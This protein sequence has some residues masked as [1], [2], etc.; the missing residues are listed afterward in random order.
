MA[1]VEVVVLIANF[2]VSLTVV[3]VSNSDILGISL[4]ISINMKK[5][6]QL[7]RKLH[8]FVQYTIINLWITQKTKPN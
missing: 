2:D 1:V 8:T 7:T 3:I 6:S 4:L 5:P